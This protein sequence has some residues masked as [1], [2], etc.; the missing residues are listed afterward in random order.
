VIRRL[1]LASGLFL[2]GMAGF[3]Y[4]ISNPAVGEPNTS[5][6]EPLPIWFGLAV[7]IEPFGILAVA[8]GVVVAK[9]ITRRRARQPSR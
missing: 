8:V 2:A 9:A 7:F 5:F 1:A 3:V 6:G 4:G